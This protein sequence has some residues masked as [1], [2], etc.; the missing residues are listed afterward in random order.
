M[1]RL[2]SHQPRSG[3]GAMTGAGAGGA[4][5]C[6]VVLQAASPSTMTMAEMA[7]TDLFVLLIFFHL[8]R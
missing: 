8:N 5:S 2:E 3:F 4:G 1:E 7:R 6:F